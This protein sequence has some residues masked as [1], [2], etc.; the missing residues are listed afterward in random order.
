MATDAEQWVRGE[1][2]AWASRDI[3][4]ILSCYTDDCVYEDLAVEKVCHGKEEIRGFIKGAFTAIP[5]FKVEIR[6]VFTSG[7]QVCIEGVLSGTH[8]GNSPNLPPPTGKTFSV[9]GAH[10][11]ELRGN[12][13]SRV[14]DY[15]NRVTMLRQL[16]VLSPAPG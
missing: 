4:T 13:A 11:C 8:T 12:R 2:A 14:T 3:E 5:D 15:Y 1:D 16:G 6:S 10:I 9:R 7:S